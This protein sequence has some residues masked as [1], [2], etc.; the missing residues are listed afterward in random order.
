MLYY[1]MPVALTDNFTVIYFKHENNK[2]NKMTPILELKKGLLLVLAR[3]P[4]L[5]LI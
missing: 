4:L 5:L 2:V 1:Q 3:A